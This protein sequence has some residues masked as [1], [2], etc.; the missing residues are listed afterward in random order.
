M[1]QNRLFPHLYLANTKSHRW[2][3]PTRSAAICKNPHHFHI[4][5]SSGRIIV[6]HAIRRQTWR[7][8][9]Y[10]Y[11]DYPPSPSRSWQAAW[12]M[13]SHTNC[14]QSC[15][16]RPTLS[17]YKQQQLK[18][19]WQNLWEEKQE[20]KNITTYCYFSA[21]STGPV[22]VSELSG[23]PAVLMTDRQPDSCSTIS[24]WENIRLTLWAHV[25][26]LMDILSIFW[27]VSSTS[28]EVSSGSK[29]QTSKRLQVKIRSVL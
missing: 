17:S 23:P 20:N 6:R 1:E 29:L 28:R 21:V 11:M 26:L 3:P 16:H 19:G 13:D 14:L 8:H 27:L 15:H 10:K 18:N 2:Y 4:S 12:H 9:L 22:T 24:P 7:H 25:Q 5:L